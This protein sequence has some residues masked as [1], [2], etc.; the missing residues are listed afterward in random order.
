MKQKLLY[1]LFLIF[2]QISALNAQNKSY[3]YQRYGIINKYTNNAVLQVNEKLII[4]KKGNNLYSIQIYDPMLKMGPAYTL[5]IS[6]QGRN[7]LNNTY[8]YTGDVIQENLAKGKC[9]INSFYKLDIY[10]NNKGY[11]NEELYNNNLSFG[12]HLRNM[13]ISDDAYYH[14]P[15]DFIRIFPIRNKPKEE[16]REKELKVKQKQEL[17]Q[18]E[19]EEIKSMLLKVNIEEKIQSIKTNITDFYRQKTKDIITSISIRQIIKEREVNKKA[20]LDYN[21]TLMIDKDKDISIIKDKR[22]YNFPYY[23][24][25]EE[26]PLGEYKERKRNPL[27]LSL[28]EECRN[29][30]FIDGCTYYKADSILFLDN[31]GL[32]QNFNFETDIIGVKVKKDELKYYSNE[33]RISNFKEVHDWCST[34]IKKKNGLYFV[35]YIVIDG[36][37]YCKEINPSNHELECLKLYLN[38]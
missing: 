8:V 16:I 37:L 31:Y 28:K 10:L 33:N 15:N 2:A 34:N 25:N 22:I 36:K 32:H 6:L 12:I 38:I 5:T 7:V 23:N 21:F 27:M 24:Y 26:H 3:T 20:T 14:I 1:L 9:L 18:N 17:H 13:Q 29:R 19:T 4:T 35:H 30:Y 11:N